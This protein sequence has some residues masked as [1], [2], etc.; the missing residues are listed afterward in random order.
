MSKLS[1][2][3]DISIQEKCIFKSASSFFPLRSR[4][5]IFLEENADIDFRFVPHVWRRSTFAGDGK[6]GKISG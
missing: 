5:C 1:I 4:T 3:V 6:L 2:N